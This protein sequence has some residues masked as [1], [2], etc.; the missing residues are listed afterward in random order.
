[1]DEQIDLEVEETKP[2]VGGVELDEVEQNVALED[3][4]GEVHVVEVV[5]V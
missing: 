5:D 4:M 2:V 3:E 1:M